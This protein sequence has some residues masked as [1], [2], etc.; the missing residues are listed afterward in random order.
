LKNS[1]NTDISKF[2]TIGKIL[3]RDEFF[4]FSKFIL[5]GPPGLL[6]LFMRHV[7]LTAICRFVKSWNI[8]DV[9]DGL[10][11]IISLVKAG[12]RVYYDLWREEDQEKDPRKRDTALFHFSVTQKKPFILVCAGGA[13]QTVASYLEAFPV[14]AEINRLGY[15]AFVLHYRTG[16]HN[17]WPAALDDLRQALHFIFNHADELNVEKE[18]YAV[19][20]FSAGGH[21]VASL[22][23]TN[24]G[25]RRWDLTKPGTLILGYPITIWQNMSLIHKH[26]RNI[27][28]SK[29][30]TQREV[31]EITILNHVDRTYP[32]TYIMH[33]KDDAIVQ[34]ESAERLANQ[35]KV[36]EV[37]YVLKAVP[38]GGHGIGLANGTSAEGWVKE[39]VQFWQAQR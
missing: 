10:N 12:E 6:E 25:Y 33:C 20:G 30:T 31:D 14:A 35:L 37:P 27:L 38:A 11:R 36:L 4:G 26:C 17:P 19:A 21:L 34:F 18:G 32:P 29:K 8:D 1:T 3:S 5:P 7:Q 39:A 28:L 16:K 24:Y 22:G 2:D 23:T 13:Y 15:S 9:V